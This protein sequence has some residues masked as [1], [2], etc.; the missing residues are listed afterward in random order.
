M[1]MF[2]V[3]VN[4]NYRL[5]FANQGKHICI[6]CF[7]FAENKQIFAVSVFHKFCFL[8]MFHC[9]ENGSKKLTA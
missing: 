9:H 3:T 6:F 8:Y 1:S 4:V 5:L 2:A 7:L